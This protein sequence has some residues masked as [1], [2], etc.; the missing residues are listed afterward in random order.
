MYGICHTANIVGWR[1]YI[2]MWQTVRD[3]FCCNY[4]PFTL[5]SHNIVVYDYRHVRLDTEYIPHFVYVGQWQSI[6]LPHHYSHPLI[7]IIWVLLCLLLSTDHSIIHTPVVWLMEWTSIK[8]DQNSIILT[9]LE[10]GQARE[11]LFVFCAIL[12]VGS[13]LS[14]ASSNSS[15]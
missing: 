8:V 12:F 13:L 14:A 3:W 7:S 6:H 1:Y 11:L 15:K 4:H 9:F 5:F 2:H 10:M